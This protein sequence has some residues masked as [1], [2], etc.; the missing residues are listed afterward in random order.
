MP[1]SPSLLREIHRRSIWQVLL[2]YVGASWAV[3]EAVQGL[4]EATGLPESFPSFAVGLLLIGFPIVMATAV[5]QGGA[6][7]R[8]PT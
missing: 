5:V 3:I 2:I 7:R 8:R 6:G 1:P 4:T